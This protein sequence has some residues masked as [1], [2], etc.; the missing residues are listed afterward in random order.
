MIIRRAITVEHELIKW[1]L[2][3]AL[4]SSLVLIY[5]ANSASDDTF[6]VGRSLPSELQRW[7]IPNDLNQGLL[8]FE[9]NEPTDWGN[10][11]DRYAL[12]VKLR[13]IVNDHRTGNHDQ[14]MLD[15]QEIRLPLEAEVWRAVAMAACHMRTG[16]DWAAKPY[17]KDAVVV[18]NDNAVTSFL[19]AELIWHEIQKQGENDRMLAS[20]TSAGSGSGP[21]VLNLAID[22]YRKVLAQSPQVDTLTTL[23]PKHWG[24]RVNGLVEIPANPPTVGELLQALRLSD[25]VAVSHSRL[26]VLY[27]RIGDFENSE[28]QLDQAAELGIDV[29]TEYLSLARK[30]KL[31]GQNAAA[32]RVFK[33]ALEVQKGGTI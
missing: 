33:K 32:H 9:H 15:W 27:E 16:D 6:P 7:A 31:S 26:G 30:L 5:A 19:K 1:F 11:A 20:Y 24:V 13:Q 4:A 28:N 12:T 10:A 23:V 2:I 22:V 25:Y 29:S 3:F 14:A 17:L 18:D 21:E 8:A